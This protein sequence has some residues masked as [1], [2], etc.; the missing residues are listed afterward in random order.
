MLKK[1][2]ACTDYEPLISEI[3]A[4]DGLKWK[5]EERMRA[6]T[7]TRITQR[8]RLNAEKRESEWMN[9]SCI[10]VPFFLVIRL[11]VSS[12][13]V[14]LGGHLLLWQSSSSTRR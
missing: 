14:I 8:V 13:N 12:E 7:I 4:F 1:L 11:N 10:R 9:K 6:P 2:H 5:M 3:Y